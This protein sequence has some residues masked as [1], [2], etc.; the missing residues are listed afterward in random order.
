MNITVQLSY[1]GSEGVSSE[2]GR[3]HEVKTETLETKVKRI[4]SR[5]EA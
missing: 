2:A 5:G 1:D 3:G 4:D